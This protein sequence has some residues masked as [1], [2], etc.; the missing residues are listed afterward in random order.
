MTC[1]SWNPLIELEIQSVPASR[2]TPEITEPR[3][4]TLPGHNSLTSQMGKIRQQK[5]K[6]LD[7][8]PSTPLPC[9]SHAENA[10]GL[11]VGAGGWDKIG[12]NDRPSEIPH[13]R[14]CWQSWRKGNVEEV[15]EGPA[16]PEQAPRAWGPASAPAL[17][18]A[19]SPCSLTAFL[20]AV[21]PTAC[22]GHVCPPVLP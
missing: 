11:G 2:T 19:R 5:P 13:L 3:V 15:K 12:W 17:P 14:Q 1:L 22:T 9:P 20:T 16:G 8:W 6:G 4:L 18:S 7:S 21:S 10:P